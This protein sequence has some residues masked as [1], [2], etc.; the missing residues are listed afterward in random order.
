MARRTSKN[1]VDEP[2]IEASEPIVEDTS[3]PIIEK[4]E[5]AILQKGKVIARALNIRKTPSKE[6]DPI[7]TLY[8]GAEISYFVENDEWLKLENG[9]YVMKEFIQ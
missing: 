1:A 5:A 4:V 8:K 9:G 6:L 3:E 7:G 2:V